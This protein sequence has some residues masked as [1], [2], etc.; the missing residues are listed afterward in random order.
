M[1]RDFPSHA[2]LLAA[3]LGTRMRPLTNTTPKPL[4][5]VAGRTLLDRVLDW[6]QKAGVQHVV[7]NTHYLADQLEAHVK[8]RAAPRIAISPE[9]DLLLETGG[10]I[11]K[12]LP[13]LGSAPFFSANSDTLCIDGEKPALQRLAAAWDDA[14]MDA[15]LLLHP[16][17]QSVGYEGK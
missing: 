15:L 9:H 7:V 3:G 5:P 6:M 16:V 12:A 2:M 11:N 1:S 14:R 4:I 13:L 17:Q 8:S 10:G